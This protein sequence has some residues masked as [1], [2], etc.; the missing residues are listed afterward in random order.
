M[1]QRVS[2][3][4]LCDLHDGE[5]RPA[6]T[7]EFSVGN[8]RFVIDLCDDD[9][10]ALDKALEPFLTA[11]RPVGRGGATRTARRTPATKPARSGEASKIR[12]WAQENG[13]DLGNRGRISAD[14]TEAYAAAQK[15]A[16]KR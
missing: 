11:A 13:Y 15:V 7:H 5:E 8:R 16:S 14:I 6:T 4:T 3:E 12:T 9:S 2:T 10:E 1:S